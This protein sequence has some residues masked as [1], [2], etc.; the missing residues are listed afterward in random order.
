MHITASLIVLSTLLHQS[1]AAPSETNVEERALQKDCNR[2]NLF[3][4]FIDPRY[5][6]SASA[7]CSTYIRPTTRTTKTTTTTVTVAN[8]KRDLP[9]TTAYPASRLSSACSCILSTT[10]SP[11]VVVTTVV[12]TVTTTKPSTCSVATPI[13]KN[14]DFE[15]G[16]LAPWSLTFVT[17]PLP[18]YSQYLSYGVKGPG[19]GGSKYA[20][21]ANDN[22][23]SS[24]NELDFEQTLTVCPNAKY[25]FTAKY[26]LTDPGDQSSKHKR[27]A[28]KQVYVYVY[29][30]DKLIAAN[31]NSD[32]AGP[33]IVWRTFT[34][35]FTTT[36]NM[37]QL[38]VAFVATDFLGVEWGLD[39]VVVSPA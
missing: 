33:P 21:I 5:S 11:I 8:A 22:A 38:K 14:G 31:L 28:S 16:S 1:L 6:S 12:A 36:S 35:T 3:R 7:F 10:P 32:P 2:D 29:I 13:V 20:L 15:A 23:A 18:E 25:R 39:N 19:F 37:A 17:P 30:D 4:S 26:Y 27:Q 9:A 34:T 24:Y